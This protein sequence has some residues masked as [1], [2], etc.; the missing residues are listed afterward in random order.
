MPENMFEK[1]VNAFPPSECAEIN[2]FQA[3]EGFV[4]GIR[5]HLMSHK[6]TPQVKAWIRFQPE[7]GV[8]TATGPFPCDLYVLILEES[9]CLF[10]YWQGSY[11]RYLLSYYIIHNL[12][13][14]H[15]PQ[16]QSPLETPHS[17]CRWA[18]RLTCSKR[19]MH[20]TGQLAKR[21][22]GSWSLSRKSFKQVWARS[23]V[24]L[25]VIP[26]YRSYMLLITT[27]QSQGQY[28]TTSPAGGNHLK[29]TA[30]LSS[31]DKNYFTSSDPHPGISSHIFWHTFWHFT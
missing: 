16:P 2:P 6:D 11:L 3:N 19:I 26:D 17:F 10:L 21:D 22:L 27:Y 20:C 15:K 14:S 25:L 7:Q 13:A 28:L 5:V 30:P 29:D 9:W 23:C 31:K 12:F 1:H 24:L 8:C 18:S 4:F